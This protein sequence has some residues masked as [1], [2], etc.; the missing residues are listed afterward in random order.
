M[1]VLSLNPNS[2]FSVN[3]HLGYFVV[4]NTVVYPTATQGCNSL[5]PREKSQRKPL[6]ALPTI[7]LEVT[8]NPNLG[9]EKQC[10]VYRNFWKDF[11][12]WWKNPQRRRVFWTLSSFFL[13]SWWKWCHVGIWYWEQWQPPC[14][15]EVINVRASCRR[16]LSWKWKG[17]MPWLISFLKCKKKTPEFLK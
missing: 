8:C 16:W 6:T 15:Q 11:P 17:L 12:A 7:E 1:C 4:A 9:Y 5:S 2:L 14:Q 10:K 3:P 13:P